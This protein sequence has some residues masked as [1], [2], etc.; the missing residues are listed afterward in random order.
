MSLRTSTTF[1]QLNASD[2]DARSPLPKLALVETIP[3]ARQDIRASS[4]PSTLP[5][6]CACTTTNASNA[7][8]HRFSPIYGQSC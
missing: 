3:F 7:A 6:A 8:A 4:F 1:E 2:Q 5:A